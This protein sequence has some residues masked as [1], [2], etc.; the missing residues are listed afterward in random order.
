MVGKEIGHERW[1]YGVKAAG[2]NPE[3]AEGQEKKRGRGN[4]GKKGR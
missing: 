3:I 4:G 1:S 2:K